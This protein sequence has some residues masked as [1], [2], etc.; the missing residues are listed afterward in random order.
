MSGMGSPTD[1]SE[2]KLKNPIKVFTTSKVIRF[3]TGEVVLEANKDRWN[4]YTPWKT[5][6][7]ENIHNPFAKKLNKDNIDVLKLETDYVVF[8]A[9]VKSENTLYLE[10]LKSYKCKEVYC[11]GDSRAPA[12]AWE[13]INDANEIARNI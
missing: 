10:L 11:V 12:S 4:P 9:G 2:D 6:V 3:E 7:P 13:A 5:L 8:A 1:K